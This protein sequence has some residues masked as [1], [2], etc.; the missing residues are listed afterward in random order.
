VDGGVKAANAP[1]LAQA[2]AT[3]LV[4]GSSIFG[5]PDPGAAV[6]ALRSASEVVNRA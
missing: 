5:A 6:A 3:V 4:A 1:L 2:G